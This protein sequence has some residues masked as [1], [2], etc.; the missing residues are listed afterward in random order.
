MK[1]RFISR[2]IVVVKKSAAVMALVSQWAAPGYYEQAQAQVSLPSFSPVTRF[3]RSAAGNEDNGDAVVADG[4][5]RGE[6]EA[7]AAE[8]TGAGETLT[9]PARAELPRAAR[10]IKA[11]EGGDLFLEGAGV[12]IP[13]YALEEDTEISITRLYATE[14]TG[15]DLENVTGE[16]GGYRFLPA[17]T[18]FAVPVTVTLPFEEAAREKPSALE[19]LSTYFYNTETSSWEA[20]NR[21]SLDEEQ[22]ALSSA[23]MHF[24]DMING[25]LALPEGPSPLSFN[26]NS[27]K[28]LEAADPGAGV[29]ALQGLEP[30][31]TGAA[32]FRFELETPPGRAGMKPAV[33]VGYSSD[34]GNG[35][36][37]KGFALEAGGE[38]TYD[39]RR[40]LPVYG[41]EE[42]N[43][44]LLDGA[45]LVRGAK[46]GGVYTYRARKETSFERI[47]H[48]TG[49]QD[50]WEV[51][52]KGGTT[53]I[54]GMRG[55]AASAD[56]SWGG[57]GAGKK[58]RWLLE[59]VTDSFGNRVRYE[60]RTHAEDVYLGDIYYTEH[61][62]ADAAYRIRFDYE[63]GRQDIRVDGRGKYISET[64]LLLKRI[65]EYYGSEWIRGYL[66]TYREEPVYGINQL[67]Q[68]GQ[69][70]ESTGDGYFWA[71][72]FDYIEFPEVAGA[73][74]LYGEQERWE[75][76]APVQKSESESFGANTTISTNGGIGT[77]GVDARVS[78]AVQLGSSSGE[79]ITEHSLVD[80]NGDGRSDLVWIS[81]GVLY[82]RLNE[83]DGF[84]GTVAFAFEGG[85]APGEVGR[86]SQSQSNSGFG[87]YGGAGVVKKALSLGASYNNVTQRGWTDTLSGFSD[88]NGDGLPDIV[89]TG[90]RYYWR[91]TGTKFVYTE[92]EGAIPAD[93]ESLLAEDRAELD[94]A[95]YQM[96]VLRQWRAPLSGTVTVR[97]TITP[98]SPMSE[99][100]Y[101]A[102]V[103]LS[104]D[105]TDFAST[106]LLQKTDVPGGAVPDLTIAVR[107]GSSLY[108][109]GD[110]RG[111]TRGDDV[112]WN[113]KINYE[114][115][116][117]FEDAGSGMAGHSGKGAGQS[118]YDE[119]REYD[120]YADIPSL[121]RARFDF[122]LAKAA[123]RSQ[124][125][126]NAL[127]SYYRFDTARQ[128]YVYNDKTREALRILDAKRHVTGKGGW[129]EL[130]QLLY[131]LWFGLDDWE[132]AYLE[133]YV[134][135]AGV[136]ADTP[137]YDSGPDD[138]YIAEPGIVAV[139]NW[140]EEDAPGYIKGTALALDRIDGNIL[141]Y[142]TAT[143]KAYLGGTELNTSG[144]PF[145]DRVFIQGLPY[146][147]D[148][149]AKGY[150]RYLPELT[151]EQMETVR[152]LVQG[153]R[154]APAS[155]ER[156]EQSRYDQL[157]P[158]LD[159]EDKA[160]IESKY[161]FDSGDGV[162]VLSPLNAAETARLGEILDAYGEKLFFETEFP[163]YEDS[164]QSGIY[165]VKTLSAEQ[166]AAL[167]TA[168]RALGLSRYSEITR[169]VRFYS[170]GFYQVIDGGSVVLPGREERLDISSTLSWD[171]AADYS[172]R[173]PRG[174]EEVR[175]VSGGVPFAQKPE[176]VETLYGGNKG[177]FYG[178][179]LGPQSGGTVFN[180]SRLTEERERRRI[181][182]Q[183]EMEDEQRNVLS[184]E[185]AKRPYY[186][187][188]STAKLVEAEEGDWRWTIE[189]EAETGVFIAD[190]AAIA[191]GRAVLS[192]PA[193]I[194]G[195]E[196][197]AP[198]IDKD[199]LHGTRAGGVYYYQL[200]GIRAPSGGGAAMGYIRKS[201]SKGKDTTRGGSVGLDISGEVNYSKAMNGVFSRSVSLGATSG[202]NT[203]DSK[204]T[205]ALQDINGDGYAD[206]LQSGGGLT[207]TAGKKGNY[208]ETYVI[209]GA[210]AINAQHTS[211]D[212]GGGSFGASGS[213][214]IQRKGN[215]S[216][217]S[218]SMTGGGSG[219]G[220]ASL[221]R[222]SGTNTQTQGL[223]DINGDGLPDS[224]A[225]GN[226]VLLNTG[227]RFQARNYNAPWSNYRLQKSRSESGGFSLSLKRGGSHS[228]D[229][230]GDGKNTVPSNFALD[231]DG[232]VN[233][234]E[235]F[236]ATEEALLDINGDGL[237]DM[238]SKT[239][240]QVMT[241]RFNNGSSFGNPVYFP[242]SGWY[243]F[244]QDAGAKDRDGPN[245][246]KGVRNTPVIGGLLGGLGL[247]QSYFRPAADVIGD[248]NSLDYSGSYSTGFSGG[249]DAAVQV[250]IP[251]PP[252]FVL[253]VNFGG[254]Q[255]MTITANKSTNTVKAQTMDMDGDGLAD[256]VLDIVDGGGHTFYVRKNLARDVGLLKGVAT[257]QGG[258]IDLEYDYL[259]GTPDMPQ[260]KHVLRGVTRNDNDGGPNRL[261][262]GYDTA[263]TYRVEYEY[264]GG[265]YDREEK[266]HYGFAKVTTVLPDNTR[267]QTN[268]IQ[269]DYRLKGMSDYQRSWND[270]W[271]Q[272]G[273]T[274]YLPG[275]SLVEE[276]RS[277]TR[278]GNGTITAT[279]RYAYDGFGNVTAI[280]DEGDGVPPLE[281]AVSYWHND[282]PY[283]HA[284]PSSI[285]V[286]SEGKT[287]RE[288]T[289]TYNNTT[290]AMEKLTQKSG[291][292][293]PDVVS[294]IEWNNQGNL[295]KI[296]SA[297][298]SY[299]RYEYD[300][301][302]GQFPRT[303]AR[304]GNGVS[305][306]SSSI[307]WNA[308]FGVKA[309][310]TDENGQVIRYIYDEY[311]R[312]AEVY[313]PY[314]ENTPAV[315]YAY[316]DARELPGGENW[317]AVTRNKI[318]FDLGNTDVIETVIVIDGLGKAIVTAK[319]GEIR[320]NGASVTGWNIG[321]GVSYDE[322]GRQ[323]AQGQPEFI[324]GDTIDN[325]LNFSFPA[326]EMFHNGVPTC[327]LRLPAV[328]E[329]DTRDRPVKVT[330]PD[331]ATQ[332]TRYAVADGQSVVT[333]TDPLGNKTVQY[334]D[335][336]QNIRAVEKYN[337]DNALQ[338]R[339]RYH[340]NAIGEML[341]ALD[342]AENPLTIEYDLMGRR[343]AMESADTGRN[344]YRYNKDG[345][346]DREND[347]VLRGR[348][349]EIRYVYDGMNRLVK[350]DYPQSEDTVY[351]Y[352]GPGANDGTA[353]RIARVSDETGGIEYKY[354]ALGETV[355]EKR[356]IRNLN[357]VQILLEPVFVRTIRYTSNY[358]GQMD[359]IQYADDEERVQ[360]TYN[361]GGQIK[362]VS[363]KKP[364]AVE[365]D[366]TFE[367]VRDTGYDE[368]GQRV[369]IEYGNGV[370]T[371]YE[372]NAE[373]RWLDRIVTRS[374]GG[375]ETYQDISYQVNAAGNIDSYKN[376]NDH[377]YTRQEYSYDDLYQLV[378]VRGESRAFAGSDKQ[379]LSYQNIYTQ[380]F[381]FDKTGNMVYKYSSG[382]ASLGDAG[383]D[384]NYRYD[385]HYSTPHRADRIGDM[386][387][388][389]DGNGSLL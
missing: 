158:A 7:V 335:S 166:T 212:T 96:Q 292:P 347:S 121:D 234:G 89:I 18:R 124:A 337:K 222:S 362:T 279:Q 66:C 264:E 182:T 356:L 187:F 357:P 232:S 24:T 9:V 82:A 137:F 141:Y 177:W 13:P 20:L 238:V 360:Y 174:E 142:N 198:F 111:D 377:F 296:S 201:E 123:E 257:P 151:G 157:L 332:T 146:A 202:T 125:Y 144:N 310:E 178:V 49:A 269:G 197:Y 138:W 76:G 276:T 1:N 109:A 266:E 344:E 218:I 143:G 241:V 349:E 102:Y 315:G 298:G 376:D 26:I 118:W 214:T 313:S 140:T 72:N 208:S 367:Y 203:S 36:M 101:S 46:N 126:V 41:E 37:G 193:S 194:M 112:D 55:D 45:R 340:Y 227:E 170:K 244:G 120:Y 223:V 92:Y 237:P 299:V 317:Y 330:L 135:P 346:L 207:V 267:S 303:V 160:F 122:L 225:D 12:H 217:N 56:K 324:A 284:H 286:K 83:G 40:G 153:D 229:Q 354:G 54:Y 221:S 190:T 8:G 192:G 351:E 115:V 369:F 388:R 167:E 281:A 248:M 186:T 219:G 328:T 180:A 42:K 173:D 149:Q 345:G 211:L 239:G 384:L 67:V 152:S 39:T 300:D 216:I 255:G 139:G 14:P 374:P 250:S 242:V 129:Y 272:E 385:Y 380:D 23:T 280:K 38:I 155:W 215:G 31:Y 6:G 386:Y 61:A 372:Y 80:V 50:Y 53:R 191:E 97:Q 145:N 159:A 331:A 316:F 295:K 147:V 231:I 311:G 278:E 128:R 318:S 373:R 319:T 116:R 77:K 312:L 282:S 365:R 169:W 322:K 309:K 195:T 361:K 389:Y 359:N 69:A 32:S 34:G 336:R 247:D 323:I 251:I 11:E 262:L 78:G 63:E 100:G 291:S 48:Y 10:L 355:E 261:A 339:A 249:L 289:G 30:N 59:S 75:G 88:I 25:T 378:K 306:Y 302:Y 168:S 206:I 5:Q 16:G 327:G 350:I 131:G 132:E 226:G 352:G 382:R 154:Y 273:F 288:R 209:T 127:L 348:G 117:L 64:R 65:D 84:G 268:Y 4:G 28:G 236:S 29:V 294:T 301:A 387:Y 270:G 204:Q 304:G 108:F 74:T 136:R 240:T 338:T 379:A 297:G 233:F 368:F 183:E 275:T 375:R 253:T 93:N 35:V 326:R 33:A 99:D 252:A 184:S 134:W 228:G 274:K 71:Y 172:S 334:A 277:V 43:A 188:A 235:S 185:S 44:F 70:A 363:G 305:E 81:G 256:R 179:W 220:G 290:G 181:M 133:Q 73:Y 119:G 200:P 342:F 114:T 110:G 353:N 94:E 371:G 165:T 358:L 2:F 307:E 60:Y 52:D 259:Y 105:D 210:G 47:R 329:Y 58:Y 366:G 79:T 199:R 381:S 224:V 86:E 62:D 370:S 271:E 98:R 246:L 150:E 156:V 243:L 91:N 287:I 27:I 230:T 87:L 130:T 314:D 254:A 171:S 341:T 57:S 175:Y 162:Y 51:T 176:T 113:I 213:A 164:T 245:I 19:N 205:R 258:T 320:E 285:V 308:R 161:V 21:V 163:Y 343:T 104:H 196:Y 22:A 189:T 90:I 293:D 321:G 106:Q 364:S 265:Y 325:V 383:S 85:P 3:E 260:G 17:G 283:F 148:Y 95:Y 68:F 263:H 15:E 333:S 107:S 103:Y